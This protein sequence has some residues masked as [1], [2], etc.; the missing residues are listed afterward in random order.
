[1]RDGRTVEKKFL[2]AVADYEVACRELR[3]VVDKYRG[4]AAMTGT[5]LA[6]LSRAMDSS[7][8]VAW[9]LRRVGRDADPFADTVLRDLAA[10]GQ[11]T[12]PMRKLK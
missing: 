12:K 2:A 1:M 4:D 7:A 11:R 6:A 3:A 8:E 9:R 5:L 10:D